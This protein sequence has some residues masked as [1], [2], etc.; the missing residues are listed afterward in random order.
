MPQSQMPPNPPSVSKMDP[1]ADP[2]HKQSTGYLNDAVN[3]AVQNADSSAFL[4]PEVLSQITA[5]VI[6]QLKASG[7]DTLQGT[8]SAAQS[9]RSQSQQPSYTA[10]ELP[11]RPNSESPSTTSQRAAS[12]PDPMANSYD[13]L[14]PHCAESGYSSDGRPRPSSYHDVSAH[15]HDSMSSQESQGQKTGTRPKPP[16]RDATLV[17]MTTLEKIW[18][19]LFE[20]GKPTKRLGQFLRGIAVHLVRGPSN[21]T[22]WYSC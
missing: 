10:A 18:G 7:L 8:G 17:E 11:P 2:P 20:D 9:S 19:K 22:C 3:S 16:S 15:R 14:H 21:G 5:T 13:S 12:V 6:Q 1:Y 4:S